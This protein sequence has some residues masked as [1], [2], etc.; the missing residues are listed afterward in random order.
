V[1]YR[2]KPVEVYQE[3]HRHGS[4]CDRTCAC[5]GVGAV[6]APLADD[7]LG[8]CD[9]GGCD[10]DAVAVRIDRDTA[11]GQFDAEVWLPVCSW[12]A[13]WDDYETGGGTR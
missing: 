4:N 2:R 11:H 9:W 1:K 6:T 13:G 8:T 3:P 7:D 10:R 5:K 12:H